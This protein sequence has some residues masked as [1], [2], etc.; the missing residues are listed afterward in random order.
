MEL[1]IIK[2]DNKEYYNID[3]IKKSNKDFFN[4]I[5]S[6]SVRKIIKVYNIPETEYDFFCFNKKENKWKESN[7]NKPSPK[8]KLFIN[9]KWCE[10]NIEKI[11]K[12]NESIYEKLPEKL[13]L[14]NLDICGYMIDNFDVRGKQIENEIYFGTNKKTNRVNRRVQ[15]LIR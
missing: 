14:D 13:L 6:S 10:E 1:A 8:A 15:V 2:I 3:N 7:K 11:K 5:R 4:K 12:E 9:K